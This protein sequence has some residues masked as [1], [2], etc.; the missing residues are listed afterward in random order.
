MAPQVVIDA[1]KSLLLCTSMD[2]PSSLTSSALEPLQRWF[3]LWSTLYPVDKVLLPRRLDLGATTL[4]MMLK[5]LLMVLK[6]PVDDGEALDRL[7]KH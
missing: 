2:N 5:T 4:L 6:P 3:V 7:E 1:T